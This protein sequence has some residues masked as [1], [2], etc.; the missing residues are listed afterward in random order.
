MFK[1]IKIL[2][3]ILVQ[4]VFFSTL[5]HAN[6]EKAMEIYSAGKFDEAKTAFEALAAIGDRS[7]LFNLGVM[8]YRGE[9]VKKD[10]VKA[11]V[12]MQIANDGFQDAVFTRISKSILNKFDDSQKKAAEKLFTELDPIY[13]IASISNYIFPKPLSDEDCT[14]EINPVKRAIP[15]YPYSEIRFGHM[16]VV[17]TEFTISPEGYPRDISITKSTSKRFTKATVKALKRALYKAPINGKPIDGYRTKFIYSIENDRA[18]DATNTKKLTRELN[19]LEEAANAGDA[20][21][22]YLYASRLNTFRHFRSYL[23]KV[24]LQYKTANSWFTKSAKSG[25][26]HAQYEI[27]RNMLEGRGC[28]IDIANGYKWINAAAIGGYSLAQNALARSALSS[29][30]I[31]F[32]KS[33]ASISWLRN[34]TQSEDYTAK[35]LLAWELSTSNFDVLRNGEEA[36]NLLDSKAD[37]YFDEVRIM[38]TRAAAYAES[39]KFKDA[40]KWQKKAQKMANKLDWDIPL[41]SERL[42]LYTQNKTYRGAYY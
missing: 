39:G 13:N 29:R 12:L 31:S 14:P 4:F 22:Q 25:L 42:S 11:Y 15:K 23:K 24:D 38:E 17:H 2:A 7:S 27:G 40:L 37:N 41:I 21:A 5:S 36:L 30:D 18:D 19:E 28:E 8:H 20:V 1:F 9:S 3:F 35:L 34:S 10:P 6:F 32:E 26:P 16:G 33:R